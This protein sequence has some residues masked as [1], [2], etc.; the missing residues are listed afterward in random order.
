MEQTQSGSCEVTVWPQNYTDV[1]PQE[2]H[3]NKQQQNGM[4]ANT[5]MQTDMHKHTVWPPTLRT[6]DGNFNCVYNLTLDYRVEKEREGGR[7]F[8]CSAVNN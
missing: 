4:L 2:M 8:S 7:S 1:R 6:I 5:H 3:I